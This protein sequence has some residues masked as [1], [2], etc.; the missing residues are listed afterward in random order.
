MAGR[1]YTVLAKP[2]LQAPEWTA[3][4]PVPSIGLEQVISLPLG[5]QQFFKVIE[6]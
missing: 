6:E 2:D 1:T 5:L 3:F 4:P